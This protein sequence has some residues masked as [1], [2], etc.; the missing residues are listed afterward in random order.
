MFE[1]LNV[2]KMSHAMAVHA[3][4]QQAV[5]AQNVANADTPGYAARELPSFASTYR[6]D[7]TA[8]QRATRQRHLNGGGGGS[9]VLTRDTRQ[10]SSPNGNNVSL[11]TE[12]MKAASAKREHDRALAIYKSGLTILRNALGR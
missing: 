11:E 8:Q 9:T 5:A 1:N 4:R 2:F 6:S 7:A 10:E 3:G 12:M